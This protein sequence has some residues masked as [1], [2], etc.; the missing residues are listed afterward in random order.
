MTKLV[1]I[2]H[3]FCPLEAQYP[4]TIFNFFEK[5]IEFKTDTPVCHYGVDCQQ[6]V[7]KNNSPDTWESL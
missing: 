4:R 7:S 3:F 2:D 1:S 5:I 6:R